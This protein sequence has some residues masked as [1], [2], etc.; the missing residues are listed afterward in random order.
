MALE[1]AAARL[2]ER[3]AAAKSSGADFPTIWNT[4]LK[5][6]RLVASSPIQAIENGEPVLKVRLA[7]NQ[8]LICGRS[9]F[10][11]G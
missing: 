1:D 8:E 4:I 5:R 3:C 2:K 9:G 11:L 7:N 6:N 10:S